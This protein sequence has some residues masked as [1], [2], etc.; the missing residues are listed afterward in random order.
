V[1]TA[2][3]CYRG[4][5]TLRLR[6]RTWWN[7]ETQF[8]RTV[9]EG[10]TYRALRSAAVDFDIESRVTGDTSGFHHSTVA[11]RERTCYTSLDNVACSYTSN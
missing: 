2:S 7:W 11:G 5:V 6:Y 8:S 9:Y 3:R 1:Y 10:E 4:A